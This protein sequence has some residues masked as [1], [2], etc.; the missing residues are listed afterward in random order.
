MDRKYSVT[1]QHVTGYA[2]L[3]GTFEFTVSESQGKPGCH[4]VKARGFGCSRD[5]HGT[6]ERAIRL[7]LEEHACSALSIE[8][9]NR[10]KLNP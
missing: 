8:L 10:R 1:V 2:P 9:L 3:C 4:Y 6:P 5:Y 7:L